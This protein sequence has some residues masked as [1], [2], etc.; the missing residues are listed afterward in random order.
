MKTTFCLIFY[1]SHYSPTVPYQVLLFSLLLK[2]LYGEGLNGNLPAIYKR[3][4]PVPGRPPSSNA[5]TVTATTGVPRPL[6]SAGPARPPSI[7]SNAAARGTSP[8]A[9]QQPLLLTNSLEVQQQ[10]GTF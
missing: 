3:M 2:L 10:V 6:S 5:A 4:S 1:A 8:V 7:C 9:R